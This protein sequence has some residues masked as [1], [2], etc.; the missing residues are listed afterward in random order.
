MVGAPSG[1]GEIMAEDLPA[2]SQ[3][4]RPSNR[5]KAM[6]LREEPSRPTRLAGTWRRVHWPDEGRGP[7]ERWPG[8]LLAGYLAG[9]AYVAAATRQWQAVPFIMLM[10][11][12]LAVVI[13]SRARAAA[14]ERVATV[15]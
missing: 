5:V 2:L 4:A 12:G 7:M 11:A 10:G 1:G 13:A 3:E 8:V 14:S 6:P 9:T 15:G